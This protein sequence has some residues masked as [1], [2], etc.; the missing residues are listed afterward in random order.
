M[1]N[2]LFVVRTRMFALV[3]L[4]VRPPSP[5]VQRKRVNTLQV[6]LDIHEVALNLW[7]RRRTCKEQEQTCTC[8][9]QTSGWPLHVR[10]C[11]GKHVYTSAA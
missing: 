2:Q 4:Q 3:L 8:K 7:R 5:Q 11:R 9:E 10:M 1:G 6:L